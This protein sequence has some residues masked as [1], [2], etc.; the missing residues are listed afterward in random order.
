MTAPKNADL[1]RP[2]RAGTVFLYT[3]ILLVMPAQVVLLA[4][5][6]WRGGLAQAAGNAL[7]LAF[8]FLRRE[9]PRELLPPP[10]GHGTLGLGDAAAGLRPRGEQLLP[11]SISALRAFVSDE[12]NLRV[13]AVCAILSIYNFVLLLGVTAVASAGPGPVEG[14]T[15]GYAWALLP[16]LAGAGAAWAAYRGLLFLERRR[17]EQEAR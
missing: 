3:Y 9:E 6:G 10:P 7:L 15:P 4:P 16:N 13:A 11:P 14:T 2:S 8:A 5:W 17:T 12:Y 1:P